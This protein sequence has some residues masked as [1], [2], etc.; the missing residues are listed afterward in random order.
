[1]KILIQFPTYG[2]P[3]KFLSVFREYVKKSSGSHSLYFNINCD[4][5]DEGMNN[6]YVKH[7]IAYYLHNFPN[8]GYSLNYDQDTTKIG[9]VNSHIDGID[10]DIV[11]CASDD[12]VP[13]VSNWDKVIADEMVKH[14]PELDGCLHF[15]DG[16]VG[17]SL[18]TFSILGVKLY[19]HFGYIYH[20]DYKGLYCDNE[21]T[22]CVRSMNKV[23]YID[24]VIVTHQHWSV[25]GS[26]NHN[27]IDMA[28]K[29]TLH[30]SGRDEF[31]YAARK[32]LNFPKERIT[33]D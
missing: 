2:R 1:M 20:P 8:T 22:D 5:D 14:F 18:I 7:R 32:E 24:Q 11:I 25:E 4:S 28:V 10:F 15:N 16:N 6:E 33:H 3:E 9:A 19:N 12:M 29:K 31:V 17:D 27:Q 30:Y 21:F 26:I 23:V 13:A